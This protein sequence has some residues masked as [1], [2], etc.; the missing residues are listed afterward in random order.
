ML[1][2]QR[3]EEYIL[4]GD[5]FFFS[6]EEIRIKMSFPLSQ[7]SNGRKTMFVLKFN[8]MNK[9]IETEILIGYV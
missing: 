8:F 5:L 7:E 9:W 4:C 1:D 6:S 3:I 2:F